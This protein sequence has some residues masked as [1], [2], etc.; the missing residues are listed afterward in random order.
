MSHVFYQLYYHFIWG[1]HSREPLIDR[2]WRPGFLKILREEI[3][4]KEGILI[5]CNA[6]PDHVH[7]LVGLPPTIKISEFIGQVKGASAFRINQEIKPRFK[8]KWQD[9]YGVISLQKEEVES[10]SRY[11][12]SQEELHHKKKLSKL[13]E[14]LK[15]V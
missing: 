15:A 2:N 6:M 7:L 4:K 11:I 14:C 12:D 13:L 10:V 8:L 3:H 1:T 5:R 9:G